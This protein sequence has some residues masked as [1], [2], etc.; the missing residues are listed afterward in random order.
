MRLKESLRSGIPLT[1]SLLSDS[2]MIDI[3]P[4]EKQDLIQQIFGKKRQDTLQIKDNSKER[5]IHKDT[6]TIPELSRKERREQRKDE[7]NSKSNPKNE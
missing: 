1:D 2:L 7:R 4:E 3:E 5:Q 6:A